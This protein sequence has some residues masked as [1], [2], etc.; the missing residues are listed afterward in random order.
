M[1][2]RTTK[3]ALSRLANEVLLGSKVA[4]EANTSGESVAKVFRESGVNLFLAHP[5]EVRR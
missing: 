2:A 5:L 4:V 3:R 1:K